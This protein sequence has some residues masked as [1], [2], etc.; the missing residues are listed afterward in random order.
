LLL[1]TVLWTPGM[2][3]TV[4]DASQR[5]LDCTLVVIHNGLHLGEMPI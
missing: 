1:R 3:M 5:I 2:M 4:D